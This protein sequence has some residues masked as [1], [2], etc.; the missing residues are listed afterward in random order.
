[1]YHASF[2]DLVKERSIMRYSNGCNLRYKSERKKGNVSLHS[3][4]VNLKY[5]EAKCVFKL[6]VND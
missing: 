3:M 2:V 1:M 4:K 5:M 6:V